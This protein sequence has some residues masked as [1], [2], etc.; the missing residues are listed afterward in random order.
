M[1]WFL[2]MGVAPLILSAQTSPV[3]I[4]N[5]QVKVVQVNEAPHVKTKLH[6]HKVN[7]VM[8]Y[9]EAGRQTINYQDGHQVVL[10]WT[11][12]EPK[13]SPAS[14]MHIAEIVSDKPVTIVEIE[15]KK[16]GSPKYRRRR[17][18]IL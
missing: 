15:L 5:E 18:W 2:L 14:G 17:R 11:A 7:R 9:L 8:I 1:K 3:P 6:Q 4:D 16:P 13:W 12:G 10:N